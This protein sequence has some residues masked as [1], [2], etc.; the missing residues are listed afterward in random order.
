MENKQIIKLVINVELRI[1]LIVKIN[2]NEH[3]K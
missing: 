3:V 1:I 2:I